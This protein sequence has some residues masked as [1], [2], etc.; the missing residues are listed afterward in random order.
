MRNKNKKKFLQQR[1]NKFKQQKSKPRFT[2]KP[3]GQ[4]SFSFIILSSQ[5]I[6]NQIA[7]F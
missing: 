6:V 7:V 2:C 1:I 5:I 3:K 4:S